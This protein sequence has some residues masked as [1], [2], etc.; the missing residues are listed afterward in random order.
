MNNMAVPFTRG[1]RLALAL[2]ALG[3]ASV[4]QA[5]TILTVQSGTYG[6]GTNGNTLDV[7]LTN[8]G[9]ASVDVAGFSF[10]VL[11]GTSNV[12]F[13]SLNLATASPYIFAGNSLFGPDITVQ[14]PFLPGQA[15]N[16]SDLHDTSFSTLASGVTVGLGRILF[17][18]APG[19]PAGP[20]A[21]SLDF[22]ATSL[23]D[24]TGSP[25]ALQM[26]GGTITV[27]PAAVPE[28]SSILMVGGA[29]AIG[30]FRRRKSS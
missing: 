26:V 28:P 16:A 20:I 12:T 21:V 4:S 29:I 10:G 30:L 14:P 13:T 5:A 24:P 17:N 3:V 27:S 11:V 2:A 9:P 8:T 22:N 6:A 18:L 23:S 1:L 15:L 7:T 25:I 19:T